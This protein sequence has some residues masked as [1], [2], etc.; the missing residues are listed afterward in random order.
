MEQKRKQRLAGALVL[1]AAAVIF[2]PLFFGR[3]M[4]GEERAVKIPE[5]PPVPEVPQYIEVLETPMEV[6]AVPAD[7]ETPPPAVSERPTLDE[8]G[9]PVSWTLQLAAFS[10]QANA[11]QLQNKLRD[12]GYRSYTR[13]GA[14]NSGKRLFRVYVGPELRKDKI[15]ELRQE[16]EKQFKLKG[17]AVRF[18]P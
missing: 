11:E 4:P 15:L 5:P 17:L 2:Y 6:P 7:Y 12:A 1:L 10:K 16:L 8:Q 9:V 18:R 14:A 3:D 13:E